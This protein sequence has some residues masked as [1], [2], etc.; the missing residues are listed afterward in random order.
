MERLDRDN[1]RNLKLLPSRIEDADYQAEQTSRP[2]SDLRNGSG[3]RRSPAE[4]LGKTRQR[5]CHNRWQIL[6]YVGERSPCSCRSSRAH[7]H[8]DRGTVSVV[9]G[10]GSCRADLCDEGPR[11]SGADV[12]A[13]TQ[14]L[15]RDRTLVQLPVARVLCP[16]PFQQASSRPPPPVARGPPPLPCSGTG[17]DPAAP[18][19]LPVLANAAGWTPPVASS[20]R[21]AE[22][23]GAAPPTSFIACSK[24]GPTSLHPMSKRGPTASNAA[25]P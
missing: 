13:P 8:P 23:V 17:A 14:R 22:G 16:G 25:F 3:C 4:T 10:V 20:G 24:P 12:Q 19:S 18:V 6:G 15:G 7:I 2:P 9:S 1:F 5:A 21:P 11:P